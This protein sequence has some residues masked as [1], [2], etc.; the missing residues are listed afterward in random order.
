M[1]VLAKLKLRLF[2]VGANAVTAY[3]DE[4]DVTERIFLGGELA[5]LV[6]QLEEAD[7]EIDDLL[8]TLMEPAA[9]LPRK[10]PKRTR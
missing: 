8:T 6:D 4:V 2:C 7:T 5:E 9:P 10:T 3:P 1:L